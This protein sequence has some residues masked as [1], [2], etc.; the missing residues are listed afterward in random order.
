MFYLPATIRRITPNKIEDDF[1]GQNL[2]EV[3]IEWLSILKAK[4]KPHILIIK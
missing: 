3:F 2:A 1:A 4:G